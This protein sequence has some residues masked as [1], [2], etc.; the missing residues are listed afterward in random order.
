VRAGVLGAAQ[1]RV[2]TGCHSWSSREYVS[3]L[4]PPPSISSMLMHADECLLSPDRFDGTAEELVDT[5]RTRRS[6]ERG[7]DACRRRLKT[8]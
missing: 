3:L 8:S 2:H 5:L 7:G 6:I 4:A 1:M